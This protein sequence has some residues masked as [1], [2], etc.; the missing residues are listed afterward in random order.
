VPKVGSDTVAL[1][2][3]DAFAGLEP[4]RRKLNIVAIA[5]L[6]SIDD[7]NL[8]LVFARQFDLPA[9]KRDYARPRNRVYAPPMSDEPESPKHDVHTS[10]LGKFIQNYSS[11]LSTFSSAWPGSWPRP[12]GST[13]SR[14][15]LSGRPNR[16]RKSR[17][18][19]RTMNGGS[20]G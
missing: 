17:P 20:L 3:D 5:L 12:F 10:R 16:N 11:L 4:T 14:K 9:C 6:E 13:G 19:R 7:A 15:P 18:P 8:G 1:A 2:T